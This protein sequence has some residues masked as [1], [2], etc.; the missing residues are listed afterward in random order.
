MEPKYTK[1]QK[2]TVVSVKD[3]RGHVKYAHNEKYVDKIGVVLDSFY[4]RQFHILYYKDHLP[5]DAYI[6]KVRLDSSDTVVTAAEE[7]LEPSV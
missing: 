6:Y 5:E 3:A 2:V 7:E 1:G 4:L